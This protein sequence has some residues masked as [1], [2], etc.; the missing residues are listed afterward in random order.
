MYYFHLQTE[1]HFIL[2]KTFMAARCASLLCSAV[3]VFIVKQIMKNESQTVLFLF[4]D[5]SHI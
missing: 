4:K 5:F 1:T 2:L 3:T